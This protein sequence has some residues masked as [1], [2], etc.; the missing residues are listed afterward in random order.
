MHDTHTPTHAHTSFCP[1][2]FKIHLE[3]LTLCHNYEWAYKSQLT[4]KLL[5]DFTPYTPG[6]RIKTHHD[7]ASTHTMTTHLNAPWQRILTNHDNASKRTMTT[8]L[9]DAIV[10]TY[11]MKQ[12][13]PLKNTSVKI[14]S[15]QTCFNTQNVLKNIQLFTIKHKNLSKWCGSKTIMNNAKI[16]QR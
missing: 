10:K 8:H 4:P 16:I 7:N 15:K 12:Q 1:I 5:E 3:S 14:Y 13:N 9:N 11:N 6:Q 2:L